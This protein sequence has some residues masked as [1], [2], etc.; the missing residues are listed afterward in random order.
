[1][2]KLFSNH[3]NKIILIIIIL[4]FFIYSGCATIFVGSKQSIEFIS[5]PTGA[6]I[7]VNGIE[8]GTTPAA[9]SLKR[10]NEYNVEFTKDGFFSKSVRVT[11]SLNVGWLI[12][13]I[14][15]GLVGVAVDGLTR[16]WNGFDITSYKVTLETLK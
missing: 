13:D 12:L 4:F 1:M 6:K 14:V 15:C 8:E 16:N 3:M 7:I 5:E 10:G 2:S 9:I 11:Y